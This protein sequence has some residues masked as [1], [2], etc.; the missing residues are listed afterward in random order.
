MFII[1]ILML[2]YLFFGIYRYYF[3]LNN[4]IIIGY[5]IINIILIFISYINV[6]SAIYLSLIIG[7]LYL[8]FITD[9]LEQWIAD[10]TIIMIL[11]IN[12]IKSLILSYVYNQNINY[13][14]TVLILV[15]ILILLIIQF[16]LKKELMGFGDLKLYFVLSLSHNAFFSIAFLLLSSLI[17]II[18]YLC[19]KHKTKY[20]P[21][22]PSIIIAYVVI[23]I[24]KTGLEFI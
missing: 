22:G 16:I 23:Y 17:G 1:Y 3:K 21:F 12:L 8:S 15:F 6:D 11:V 5:M 13:G 4:R 2:S 10:F 9:I 19:L 14:G 20:F 24:I 18:Y 7:F